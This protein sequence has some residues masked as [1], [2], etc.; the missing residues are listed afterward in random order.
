MF[1]QPVHMYTHA[2]TQHMQN[3]PINLY[4]KYR[5]VNEKKKIVIPNK[6]AQL[7]KRKGEQGNSKYCQ[8]F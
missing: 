1:H 4:N 8:K 7:Q 6:N 2:H 5:L 3:I